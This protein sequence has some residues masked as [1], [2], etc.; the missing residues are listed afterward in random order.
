MKKLIFS[1]VTIVKLTAVLNFNSSNMC[2]IT[3]LATSLGISRLTIPDQYST[4]ET[5]LWT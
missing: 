5:K 1:K 2:F 3:I 4:Y